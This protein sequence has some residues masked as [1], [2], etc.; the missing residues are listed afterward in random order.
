MAP[1]RVRGGEGIRTGPGC[2]A[3]N[4]HIDIENPDRLMFVEAWASI[5]AVRAHFAVPEPAAF[6]AEM[7]ALSP[8]PPA[9]R[10]YSAKDVTAKL[11]GALRGF[12]QS[13]KDAEEVVCGVGRRAWPLADK[14][15]H[16]ATK[17]Q[18]WFNTVRPEL[19][20]GPFFLC[21]VA[22]R[23][24][25]DLRSPSARQFQHERLFLGPLWLRGFVRDFFFFSVFAAL[26]ETNGDT[27][28][29]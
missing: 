19:V 23:M 9:I 20:E 16:K 26:R 14:G 8:Q 3:H 10:I 11:M 5:D 18:R 28:E 27:A 24:V 12:A 4:C 22:R 15:S 21:D 7:R 6:V 1:D 25:G 29:P 2:L 17:P 13:R